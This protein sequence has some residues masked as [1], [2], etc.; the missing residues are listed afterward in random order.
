MTTQE[1]A[2]A[3]W[4]KIK[5][6]KELIINQM[7]FGW[8]NHPNRTSQMVPSGTM[9]INIDRRAKILSPTTGLTATDTEY[10]ADF[11]LLPAYTRKFIPIP[12]KSTFFT[13]PDPL[14]GEFEMGHQP[15]APWLMESR[16]M[17]FE[18]S[19]VVGTVT[20]KNYEYTGSA[21]SLTSTTTSDLLADHAFNIDYSGGYITPEGFYSG[22]FSEDSE[23]YKVVI[24]CQT[25]ID[26]LNG[27]NVLSAN[28]KRW[29]WDDLWGAMNQ[30]FIEAKSIVDKFNDFITAQNASATETWSGSLSLTYNFS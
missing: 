26:P 18:T 8:A 23:D 1:K 4:L 7:R 24:S 21:W 13:A 30:D 27:S 12:F 17:V 3:Y 19:A 14:P 28:E 29:P 15:I 10:S 16:T 22:G 6:K 11:S 20:Q 5:Q 25:S 9:T 2:L